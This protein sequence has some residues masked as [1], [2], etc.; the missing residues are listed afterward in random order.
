MTQNSEIKL[1]SLITETH[2]ELYFF[3]KELQGRYP[4]LA[5]R[6]DLSM[7]SKNQYPSSPAGITWE[8]NIDAL[9][10]IFFFE[11]LH[12]SSWSVS[13]KLAAIGPE[14]IEEYFDVA[15]EGF[16]EVL[17]QLPN[18]INRFKEKC[19]KFLN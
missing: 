13:A 15:F 3:S 11:L 16:P 9:D 14:T 18:F 12:E 7:Y 10:K 8:I 1:L 6:F 5:I 19:Q 17:T 2:N 4:K